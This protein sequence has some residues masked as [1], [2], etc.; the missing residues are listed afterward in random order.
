VLPYL[1]MADNGERVISGNDLGAVVD[2]S[3]NWQSTHYGEGVNITQGPAYIRYLPPTVPP[4]P[5]PLPTPPPPY[6]APDW[7][8]AAL[9]IILITIGKALIRAVEQAQK[10]KDTVTERS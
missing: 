1:A 6:G 10:T 3:I 8:L 9:Q 7:V 5:V 4:G 2:F